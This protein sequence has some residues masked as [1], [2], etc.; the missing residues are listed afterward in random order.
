MVT[1][2]ALASVCRSSRS[3]LE[4]SMTIHPQQMQHDLCASDAAGNKDLRAKVPQH[5]GTAASAAAAPHQSKSATELEGKVIRQNL[6]AKGDAILAKLGFKPNERRPP[7]K[8]KTFKGTSTTPTSADASNLPLWL[9][10]RRTA[11]KRIMQTAPAPPT[12]HDS[13]E[14]MRVDASPQSGGAAASGAASGSDLSSFQGA[15]RAWASKTRGS[16]PTSIEDRKQA[17]PRAKAHGVVDTS[18]CFLYPTL[19]ESTLHEAKL[20]QPSRRIFEPLFEKC[21]S[22]FDKSLPLKVVCVPD[23]QSMHAS[24]HVCT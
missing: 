8:N 14:P 6:R 12:R 22:G 21:A 7:L 4:T 17:S 3:S 2:G 15:S 13:G 20:Y 1:A 19:L 10:P 24:L 23:A 9:Q 18:E 16:V 11:S 5:Y